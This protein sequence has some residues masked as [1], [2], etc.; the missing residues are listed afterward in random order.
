MG[1]SCGAPGESIFLGFTRGS[2]R[3]CGELV[4]ARYV[5]D[6]EAV[7]LERLCPRHGAS[8]A[9]VAESLAWYLDALKQPLA[10]TPPP[11]V[12]TERDGSCPGSCGPCAFH[13]QQCNLPVFSITNACDLRCP[14]CF[15]Y[16]REDRIYHMSPEEFSRHLDF[17][18]QATGGVEMVNITG[19]EPTLHPQLP[20]LLDLARRPEVGRVTVN[21][22]GL[23][24]ARDPELARC[25]ADLGVHVILSLNTL[26]AQ[27]SRR[28][29]GEDL[30]GAKQQ[31]LEQLERFEVPTTLLMVLAGEINEDQLGSLLELTLRHDFVRSLSVQTMTYTGQGGGSF[32]PRRHIPVDGVQRRIEQASAGSIAS[33]DFFPLPTAHPLCY[34]VTYLLLDD[35]RQA[36]PFPRLLGRAAMARHLAGGYLLQPTAQLEQDLREAV[37]RLRDEGGDPGLLAAVKQMLTTLYPTGEDLTAHQRKRRAERAVKTIYVHAQMDEDTYEVGRA[38]RCPDQVPVHAERLVGACSYNLFYRKQDRRFW[39]EP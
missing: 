37:D 25:L 30:T 27:Q 33:D 18:V 19:G 28:L 3:E 39:N 2:C 20:R 1:C 21:T 24:L 12:I 13:G 34:G 5:S 9:L 22:N 4:D 31:A 14:I 15:T 29:H 17:V 6:G 7:F 23:T 16:N 11:Q 10:A 8:S 38:M 32:G 26:D 36:H 35:Q